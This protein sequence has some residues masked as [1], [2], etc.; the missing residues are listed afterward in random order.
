MFSDTA[1][2]MIVR[3]VDN[4]IVLI[5]PSKY[6]VNQLDSSNTGMGNNSHTAQKEL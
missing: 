5:M 4:S 6:A 2:A 3:L 1:E